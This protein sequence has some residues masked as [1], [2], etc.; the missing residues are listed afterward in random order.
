MRTLSIIAIPDHSASETIRH[1]MTSLSNA[2]GSTK[3]LGFPPHFSLWGAFQIQD[4]ELSNLQKEIAQVANDTSII[5][6]TLAKYGFYPWRIVY[7]EIPITPAVKKAHITV[8]NVVQNRR[9]PWVP[10][11]LLQSTD[12]GD[13]QMSAIKSYGYQFADKYYSPHITL[14]GND[15]SQAAFDN[16]QQKL[17]EASVHIPL[18]ADQIALVDLDNENTLLETYNL[19]I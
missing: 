19:A 5:H 7:L 15:M 13:E 11:V 8:M 9:T 3:A 4:G 14:T 2:T 1:M 18:S 12:F 10:K 6:L 17:K 16:L